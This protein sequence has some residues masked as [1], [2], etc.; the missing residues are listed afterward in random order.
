MKHRGYGQDGGGNGLSPQDLNHPLVR[1]LNNLQVQL[2]QMNA[3]NQAK[4][5]QLDAREGALRQGTVPVNG[6][7]DV[8]TN[9]RN[10]LPDY[11]VP[12][13]LGDVNKVIWPFWFTNITPELPAAVGGTQSQATAMVTVTQEA[14]FII[15]HFMKSV[16]VHTSITPPTPIPPP[17]FGPDLLNFAVLGAST[18]T[19]TGPTL[20]T[21]DLGVSPGTAI[22]GFP[23]GVVFG[24]QHSADAAAAAAQVQ[25]T[26]A[27]TDAQGRLGATNLTG[28]DLGGMTLTPGIYKF[29]TSAQLTG[30][31]TLDAQGNANAQWIFQIGSTLTTATA[32]SVVM[33]NGGVPGNVYWAVGSSATLGTATAF[34]GNIMAQASITMVTGATLLGRV[35]ARVG[36]VTMDTNAI[37]RVNPAVAPAPVAIQNYQYVDPNCCREG[38]SPGL[39][40]TLQDA[41][42][43]RVFM[44]NPMDLDTVGDG[45]YPTELPT[46]IM[47][48]PNSVIK[49]Q[50]FNSNAV[51]SYIPWITFLGV[52]CRIE[53][54]QRIMSL[55][56]G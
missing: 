33:I 54:A 45:V 17:P 48:L 18:D 26:A 43:S 8:M 1:K 31:L 4:K 3:A 37:T 5:S 11:L 28:M 13:N 30:I 51:N 21:G 35:L 56:T 47:F 24:V 53:D 40:M 39:S 23:P 2:A 22:V 32:S 6:P 44:S 15:T 41:Q 12:G 14:A 29:A 16:F 20:V 34:Q 49:T 25:L 7:Q 46:P 52:R 36:A 50:L 38:Y 10:I 42:S 55:I 9:L 27:Y 19:N